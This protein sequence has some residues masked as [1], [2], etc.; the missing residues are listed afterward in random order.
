MEADAATPPSCARPSSW[1]HNLGL[2][3]VAEGVETTTV[4]ALLRRWRATGAGL[5]HEPAA[6]LLDAAG[7]PGSGPTAA[8]SP[9]PSGRLARGCRRHALKS[10]PR[11]VSRS[12]ATVRGKR[13]RRAPA[14]SCDGAPVWARGNGLSASRCS[15]VPYPLWAAK[16]NPGSGG[17]VAHEPVT[18]GLGQ[19]RRGSYAARSRR[20]R[21]RPRRGIR[22]QAS[23]HGN[24][25]HR[26]I[27]GR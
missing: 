6:R 7:E 9:A 1:A 19:D 2:T 26:R 17:R 18:R 16:Q 27:L 22:I 14:R 5:L 4:V 20:R 10:G 12:M 24:D 8:G 25:R 3:V 21:S 23:A 11:L 15:G 13:H